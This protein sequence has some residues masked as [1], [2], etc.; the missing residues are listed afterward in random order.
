MS[1]H[2]RS[3][4]LADLDKVYVIECAAHKSPWSLSILRDCINLGYD[5]RVLE[6]TDA[7]SN[8]MIGYIICRYR[9]DSCHILNLCIA[10]TAQGKGYGQYL[11]EMMLKSLQKNS[12]KTV[13]L[14]VRPSN[15]KA[16]DLYTKSGFEQAGTKRGYYRDSLGTEDAIVLKKILRTD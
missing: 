3:M 2:V 13:L 12:I 7:D 5:C 11:L 15:K 14:E 4:R 6:E 1:I 8:Q 10:S 9:E 16:L